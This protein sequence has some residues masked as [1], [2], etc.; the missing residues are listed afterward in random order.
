MLYAL[1]P[2]WVKILGCLTDIS[3]EGTETNVLAVTQHMNSILASLLGPI[4]HITGAITLVI[5]FNL[6]L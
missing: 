2:V 1:Y 6:G 5:T 4:A 3:H